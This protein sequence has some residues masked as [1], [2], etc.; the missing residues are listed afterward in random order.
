MSP[1]L[2]SSHGARAG[3]PRTCTPVRVVLAINHRFLRE[4]LCAL[5]ERDP[6]VEVLAEASDMSTAMR[7]VR[8]QRPQV[9]V[10][11][12]NVPSGPILTAI[13]RLRGQAT[14]TAIVLTTMVD[15]PRLAHEAI[16]AGA[17]AYVLA[18]SADRG[19]TA[20][21]LAAAAGESSCDPGVDGARAAVKWSPRAAR[22]RATRR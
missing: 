4:S 3:N 21:I 20:A 9:L 22:L 16:A 11:G 14:D 15:D 10:L 19:L 5:L 6:A 18:D 7:Q 8:D 2:S 17:S 1:V 13:R 12:P